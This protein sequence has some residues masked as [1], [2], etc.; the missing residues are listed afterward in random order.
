MKVIIHNNKFINP[1]FYLS[2]VYF[3]WT[4]S[5]KFGLSNWWQAIISFLLISGTIYGLFKKFTTTAEL[6]SIPQK[7]FNSKPLTKIYLSLILI[8]V[9]TMLIFIPTK[10]VVGQS[11]TNNN[12]GGMIWDHENEPLTD[13]LV[14][15]PELNLVDTTDVYGK[16]YFE[17]LDTNFTS[18]TIIAY[19][20]GYHTF[21]GEGT[22]GNLYYNFNMTKK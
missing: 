3:L 8:T 7:V 14:S 21:E 17:S 15:L 6:D 16:F 11:L 19:K 1:L 9:A 20:D 10:A 22:I 5:F 2:I 13:V 18:I 4:L 12:F